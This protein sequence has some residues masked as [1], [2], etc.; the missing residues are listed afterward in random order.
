MANAAGAVV[1]GQILARGIGTI[2]DG[3]YSTFV[4]THWARDQA[5]DR[6][7]LPGRLVRLG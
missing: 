3:S 6:K 2:F 7:N 4:Q 5:Q 1:K